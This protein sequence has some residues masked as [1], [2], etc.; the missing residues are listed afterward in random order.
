MIP[1]ESHPVTNQEEFNQNV[2]RMLGNLYLLTLRGDDL[3]RELEDVAAR[4]R[5]AELADY[6]FPA[7][8]NP[9]WDD[10]PEEEKARRIT[11]AQ[12]LA[13]GS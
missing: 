5:L 11:D 12:N 8:A 7:P 3:N 9:A 4:D 13:F 6:A 1:R 10:L 2:V